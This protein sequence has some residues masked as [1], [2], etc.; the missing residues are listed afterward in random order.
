MNRHQQIQFLK[1]VV[2][3][4]L[5]TAVTLIIIFVCKSLLGIN[6]YISNALGYI[7]GVT[8]SFLWNRSWVFKSGGNLSAEA[9]KFLIGFALCYA[10]QFLF[11][12]GTTTLSPLGGMLWEIGR[13]TLSGYGVATLGG[14]CV[15]TLCN[16]IYN[17]RI[18]F[19]SRR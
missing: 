7:G 2:V 9:T 15:Y 12:W 11:V 1:F 4:G 8:N 19:T 3:G 5:N 13:F 10:L 17:R 6:P 14:M 16:F 18:A